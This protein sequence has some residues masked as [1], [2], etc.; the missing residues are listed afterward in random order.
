MSATKVGYAAAMT[1]RRDLLAGAGAWAFTAAL[2]ARANPPASLTALLDRTSAALLAEYPDS[3]SFLGLDTGAH[4]ALQGQLPDQSIAGVAARADACRARSK[5]LHAFDGTRLTGL[6]A[7][8]LE[9]TRYAHALAADGYDRFPYGDNEVLN[10]FQSEATS[11]YAVSQGSGF[12]AIMPD[13][14]DTLHKVETT[15]HAEAY[16]QRL[17]AYA[18]GLDG[19]TERL[20]RDAGLGVIAPDFLLDTT[21]KQQIAYAAVPVADWGLVS[22]LA[23]RAREKALPGD[24]GT[25]ARD[26]CNTTVAPALA[27]QI[28]TLRTLRAK[29]GH[30]AGVARLPD[31]EAYYGWALQAGTTTTQTAA[32]VHALGLEQVHAI[33]AKMDRLLREQGFT[34]GTVGQRMSALSSD[35]RF[36]FPND[37]GGRAQLLA[38]L[39]RVIADMRTRLPR[40]FAT[41][42]KAD[43]VIKRVPPS[44]EAGAPDGYE[45]N[46]P[47]DG[48]APSI[49]YINLRDTANW[50][51]FS[52]PT[53]C[54][55]EGLPG[56]VWQGSFVND[57]PVIRSQL[58]FNAYVEG[59]AL[60]AEQLGDELGAY[61]HDPFGKLGFLQSIQFRACRLVVDTGLHAKRWS[62]E[63][64]IRWMV[65]HNGNPVDSATGEIDRYCAWPGQACGYQIG[66]LQ[67]SALR[68]QARGSLG[69]RF[70]LRSFDDALLTSG[71][72]PL[73]LLRQVMHGYVQS[74]RV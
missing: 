63:Q 28:E 29:A 45:E 11:P 69:Q 32:E 42:K 40:A 1:T 73:D 70:D 9:A 53:L 47:I 6:D 12:F 52:L 57:L 22:S 31:G 68:R 16:L 66:H 46:G 64:A 35:P 39:N 72:M 60:Y 25:R 38:Y 44:I 24:W 74:R 49:Y 62:R 27:R 48:S 50:P 7:V 3:A 13:L 18:R 26:I 54:F 14:L 19:E 23:R 41:L 58:V 67:I 20:Q 34:A 5:E 65:E 37:E 30:E 8:N 33:S 4:A 2:G 43:L 56:H 59:W 17:D 10:T 36:L 51:K 71:S 21:L 61:E 15:A 55:H